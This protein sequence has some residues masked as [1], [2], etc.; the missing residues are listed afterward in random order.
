MGRLKVKRWKRYIA[1][2]IKEI[3]VYILLS[4]YTSEQ[5]ISEGFKRIQNDKRRHQEDIKALTVIQL[6]T[7]LQNA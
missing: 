7:E 2:I 6:T 1:Q 5:E 4:K 3:G